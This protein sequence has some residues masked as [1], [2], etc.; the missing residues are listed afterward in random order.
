MRDDSER[1][2]DIFDVKRFHEYVLNAI[3]KFS[4]T[5]YE[6]ALIL[7]D[8]VSLEYVKYWNKN[9]SD[10]INEA[11]KGWE[12]IMLNYMSSTPIRNLY[13]LN[14]DISS[15]QAYIINNKAAKKFINKYYINFQYD[16]TEYDNYVADNFIFNIFKTYCYKY[17]YFTYP[18]NNDSTIHS[19]HLDFHKF[20]KKI[21]F[22]SWAELINENSKTNYLNFI[23][24]GIIIVLIILIRHWNYQI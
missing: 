23:L 13:E 18:T 3:N 6:Y 22:E 20:A 4:E 8:D 12:I 7:E 15:T 14:K 11:P 17:P 19:D 1:L 10:I 2:L 5:N 9:I 21:A 24:I 16:L